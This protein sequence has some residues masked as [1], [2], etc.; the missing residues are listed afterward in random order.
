MAKGGTTKAKKKSAT[1][2]ASEREGAVAGRRASPTRHYA[3]LRFS[4]SHIKPHACRVCR[5]PVTGVFVAAVH[6]GGRG[7]WL[8]DA[9]H[10]ACAA[11]VEP[12]LARDLFE[13]PRPAALARAASSLKDLVEGVVLDPTAPCFTLRSLHDVGRLFG[14]A[15]GGTCALCTR[16]IEGVALTGPRVDMGRSEDV[17]FHL[18]CVLA[19]GEVDR[20]EILERL[21]TLAAGQRELADEAR[22]AL[23]VA[24][25]DAAPPVSLLGADRRSAQREQLGWELYFDRAPTRASVEARV[26]GTWSW[27]EPTIAHVRPAASATTLAF[28]DAVIAN[29]DALAAEGLYAA[30]FCEAGDRALVR[31]RAREAAGRPPFPFPFVGRGRHPRGAEWWVRVRVQDR[32]PATLAS[33]TFDR[34]FEALRVDGAWMSFRAR[35]RNIPRDAPYQADLREG[36]DEV[37]FA[38]HARAPIA[39]VVLG[40]GDAEG[41]GDAWHE[42]SVARVDPA[43]LA[44]V[45][46]TGSAPA[47][48]STADVERIRRE[49]RE[50]HAH[51]DEMG[52]PK[53]AWEALDAILAE[54]PASETAL[55]KEVGALR[56]DVIAA[57]SAPQR[58]RSSSRRRS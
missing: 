23:G 47:P 39:L 56:G 38:L 42:H 57:G 2:S 14:L 31:A 37:L 21:S 55:R 4:D 16:A 28:R 50:A 51:A 3:E 25:T 32:A 13:H 54:I 30:S 7:Q 9:H 5:E 58:P 17:P 45:P 12:Q 8:W 44:E 46:A 20:D 22:R 40:D 33:R 19:S 52:D 41:E 27:E 18:P 29:V 53:A 10:P 26:P 24:T 36:L 15:R 34:W 35:Y 43:E 49:A 48:L 6:R 1:P 11:R